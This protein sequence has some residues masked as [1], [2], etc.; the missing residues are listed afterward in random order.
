MR[1]KWKTL[2]LLTLLVISITACGQTTKDTNTSTVTESENTG[3]MSEAEITP[4]SEP[5]EITP[6]TE[7]P[8]PTVT[9]EPTAT[10]EPAATNAPEMVD[11]LIVGTTALEIKVPADCSIVN[12][13][14]GVVITKQDGMYGAV[15]YHGEVLVPNEYNYYVLAPNEQGYFVLGQMDDVGCIAHVFDAAGEEKLVIDDVDR[16]K[17]YEDKI[18]YTCWKYDYEA[19]KEC[20]SVTLYDMSKVAVVFQEETTWDTDE[21]GGFIPTIT[22]TGEFWYTNLFGSIHRIVVDAT[23]TGEAK[24]VQEFDVDYEYIWSVFSDGFAMA[25]GVVEADRGMLTNENRT[26]IYN[27]DPY[28][29]WNSEFYS[30]SFAERQ[31]FDNGLYKYNKGKLFVISHED[32]V[33][34]KTY[35][36]LVNM[37]KAVCNENNWVL[38]YEEVVVAT[39]DYIQLSGSP[40]YLAG[41]DGKYF[42]IDANGQI[43]HDSF[44]D[45]ST[46]YNGYAMIIDVDG[47]AYMIDEDFNKVAGGYEADGVSTIGGIFCVEKDGEVLYLAALGE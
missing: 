17:S 1:R 7:T 29:I 19:D 39:Y 47:C 26:E 32:A 41:N 37:E 9:P 16:L 20:G 21:P 10:P 13:C 36:H 35:Y 4:S 33:E 31:Y 5:V 34:D 30:E 18:I 25:N 44:L 11:G 38:N 45:Y 2:S 27:Y 15:N 22:E 14:G 40:Y 23:G 8:A 6:A 42:Y 12:S 24:V 3:G 28:A 46:F 43:V